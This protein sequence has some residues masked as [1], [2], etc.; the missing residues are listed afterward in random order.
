MLPKSHRPKSA[1]LYIA[2][3]RKIAKSCDQSTK[4]KSIMWLLPYFTSFECLD[5]GCLRW[6]CDLGRASLETAREFSAPNLEHLTTCGGLQEEPDPYSKV[7]YV[8]H[9]QVLP[10]YLPSQATPEVCLNNKRDT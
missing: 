8:A 9:A 2:S 7:M 3:A 5:C 4:E 10:P 6:S 1:A